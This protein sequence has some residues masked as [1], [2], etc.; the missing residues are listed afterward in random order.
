MYP[1]ECI[2]FLFL[3]LALGRHYLYLYSIPFHGSMDMENQI[4]HKNLQQVSETHFS[5]QD[6]NLRKLFRKLH[7]IEHANVRM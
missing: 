7:K 3:A 1:I 4:Q 5:M 2:T 6:I